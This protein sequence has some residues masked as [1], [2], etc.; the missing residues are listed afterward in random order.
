MQAISWNTNNTDQ[1]LDD[2]AVKNSRPKTDTNH[3]QIAY[4]TERIILLMMPAILIFRWFFI[5][6]HPF[7]SMEV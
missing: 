7:K 1:L 5:Y 6:T 4:K 3:E 2:K